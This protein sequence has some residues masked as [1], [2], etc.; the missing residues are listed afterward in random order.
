MYIWEEIEKEM[1]EEN[2]K[3]MKKTSELKQ[4]INENLLSAT[5]SLQQLKQK[6]QNRI[7]KKSTFVVV[8]KSIS[9]TSSDDLD[10]AKT[11]KKQ[12]KISESRMPKCLRD[13]PKK[14]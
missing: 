14:S 2:E 8:V 13:I 7:S 5:H 3:I 11:T 4:V 9:Q 1:K 10:E 12:R 6:F